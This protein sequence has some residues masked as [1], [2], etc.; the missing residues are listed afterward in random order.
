MA[1]YSSR[2]P[3][4]LYQAAAVQQLDRLAID[5]FGIEGFTL[6]QRAGRACFD[7]LLER[8]PETRRLRVF[9]GAGNNAGDG[10]VIA[11]SNSGLVDGNGV[12]V[13]TMQDRL[14]DPR[15]ADDLADGRS[16]GPSS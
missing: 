8:W 5:T 15:E 2:L 1:E 7:A 6:M 9:A 12:L 13:K 16:Y 10:Y 4:D 3:R 11:A 14:A